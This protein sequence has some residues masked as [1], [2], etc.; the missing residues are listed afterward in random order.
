MVVIAFLVMTSVPAPLVKDAPVVPK[1]GYVVA[2]EAPAD[3]FLRTIERRIRVK[4]QLITLPP[5]FR[6]G[7]VGA[8]EDGTSTDAC[9]SGTVNSLPFRPGVLSIVLCRLSRPIIEDFE[10][11]AGCGTVNGEAKLF[12]II[13]L[14][15]CLSCRG[16]RAGVR[17]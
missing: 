3:K 13:P 16:R 1:G 8:I 6:V 4:H 9:R 15:D 7:L 5:P 11:G 12:P 2:G 14:A 17:D 10:T